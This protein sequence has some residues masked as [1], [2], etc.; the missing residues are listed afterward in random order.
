MPGRHA[1]SAAKP[2]RSSWL[3]RAVL[4]L[5]VVV[6][7]AAGG[8]AVRSLL[9]EASPSDDCATTVDLTVVA[10]PSIAVTL[11]GVAD[12]FASSVTCTAVDVRSVP[13][14]EAVATLG[15][16]DG[17]DVW[18][19]ETSLWAARAGD[20]AGLEPNGS[21]ALSPLVVVAPREA[22]G[23]LG[24][25]EAEV[26]WSSLLGDTPATLADPATT[27]E[28]LASLLAVR[29][30]MG[31]S[32]DPTDLVAAMSAMSKVTVPS[33][34]EAYAAIDAQGD[35]APFFTASEQSVIA[36]NATEPS[37]RVVAIYPA[38]GTF[39]FD[40]PAYSVGSPDADVAEARA[41]FI[42]YL[43]GSEAVAAL[44]EAGYRSADGLSAEAA[45]VVD[46]TQSAMPAL[47]PAPEAEAAGA[48]LRQ[49][50]ALALQMR[51]LAVID[52]SGSMKEE[53]EGGAT[54]IELTRDAAKSA[55]GLLPPD[56]SVG[57][58]A[59]SILQ[60]PPNDYIEL[61]GLG[62]LE[63]PM[64]SATRLE[65]L[66]AASDTLPER[67]NGGTGLYDTAMAAFQHVRST[68]ETGK[69]N[70]VVLMTDGRNED[71]P[72]GID[73]ETL[74]TTLQAQFDPAA[75][76][77]IITIGMGPDADMEALTQISEATGASAYQAEDPRDIEQVFLKAMIE[78]QC[79][80]NC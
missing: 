3:L 50:A 69:V 18:V 43:A 10:D 9:G 66:A 40:Y 29:A 55:L 52:V 45:G 22:A 27:G 7:V 25:P 37:T 19:P 77:P 11:T 12:D 35:Q 57:L 46:G 61:V 75:P 42:D 34:A 39:A 59:F 76:V 24:W 15:A 32:A 71:D 56:S 6:I 53:V 70:S 33:V 74:L 28:G 23:Q 26:S 21:V 54:R 20:A 64:G 16:D 36:H 8:I 31:D 78:R 49:W 2:A 63:E 30:A 65:A 58:W 80:P 17:P 62:P 41:A 44:Q 4:S 67:A 68:Y 13:S 1:S 51:M 79:R 73:L 48:M 72:D 47:L 60:D 5:G 38:E 14:A